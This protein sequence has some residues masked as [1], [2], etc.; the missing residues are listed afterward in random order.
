M[1]N[2]LWWLSL[3]SVESMQSRGRIQVQKLMTN[4]GRRASS[5]PGVLAG[6]ARLGQTNQIV[7]SHRSRRWLRYTPDQDNTAGILQP[8][9]ILYF[10]VQELSPTPSDGHRDRLLLLLHKN[11]PRNLFSW[12]V[13]T[14]LYTL[15]SDKPRKSCHQEVL[16]KY[17]HRPLYAVIWSTLTAST[18]W[19]QN[20]IP[21]R[22]RG[23]QK[24][25]N[26]RQMSKCIHRR[27]ARSCVGNIELMIY[28]IY[29]LW[30][31]H[32]L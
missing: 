28:H 20:S 7:V 21:H 19:I 24:V 12:A 23:R 5:W 16:K 32:I 3:M 18:L 17:I 4:C 31:F 8:S 6:K 26:W 9:S 25:E 11:N 10:S 14:Q 13:C 22:E 2:R 30:L 29:S 1:A 15:H 27:I